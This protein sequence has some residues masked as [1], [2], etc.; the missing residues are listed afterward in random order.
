MPLARIEYNTLYC[1]QV[2]TGVY[3]AGPQSKDPHDPVDL[4]DSDLLQC[5]VSSILR[6]GRLTDI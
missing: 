2:C 3:Q 6:L 5:G 4:V 1:N